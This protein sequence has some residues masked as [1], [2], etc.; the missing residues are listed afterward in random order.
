[1]KLFDKPI[2]SYVSDVKTGLYVILAVS[3]VRFL[4]LPVFNVPYAEG[5]HFV[6]ATIFL[7]LAW[8]Y[9]IVRAVR[10]PGTS[11]R[12]LLGT[13]VALFIP[14]ALMIIVFILI[15]DLG[16]INTYYTDPAHGG[17]LNPW[18][19]SLGHLVFGVV[20]SVIFWGLGSLIHFIAGKSRKPATA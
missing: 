9:Y 18:M 16:G 13:T 7:A 15:D 12:D 4:M 6:S 3:V 2:M 19:H 1:M 20:T 17:E 8:L 14:T 10:T 5:T 11:Y